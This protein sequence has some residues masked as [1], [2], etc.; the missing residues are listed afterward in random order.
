MCNW[1]H[2]FLSFFLFKYQLRE[3]ALQYE[4][5]EEYRDATRCWETLNDFKRALEMLCREGL[6]PEALDCRLRL[7]E[8]VNKA[9]ITKL[10]C[11]FLL[12]F[13]I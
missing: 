4:K 7:Q 9:F 1:P 6:F 10:L 5:A 2:T 13:K 12:S 3:A 11:S 8:I